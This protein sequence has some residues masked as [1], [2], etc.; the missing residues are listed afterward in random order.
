MI[1]PL[2]DVKVEEG[3][4]IPL[5]CVISKSRQ[6][7][8]WYKNGVKIKPIDRNKVTVEDKKHILNVVDSEVKDSAEYSVK[9]GD[10][11]SK[12]S[13]VVEGK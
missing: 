7:A 10:L 1:T 13:V 5:E 2:A 12:A 4:T 6:V 11:E 8:A 3:E 9:F